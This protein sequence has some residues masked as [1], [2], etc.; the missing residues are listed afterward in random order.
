MEACALRRRLTDLLNPLQGFAQILRPQKLSLDSRLLGANLRPSE[1]IEFASS[2]TL[3]KFGETRAVA[4][5]QLETDFRRLIR[6]TALALQLAEEISAKTDTEPLYRAISN[7]IAEEGDDVVPRYRSLVAEAALSCVPRREERTQFLKSFGYDVPLPP[8]LPLFPWVIVFILDFALFL[9]PSLVMLNLGGHDPNLR[10]APLALF[11]CV[12]AISQTV[13]LTW[14]I[15]P[16][17]VSNF[18][19][20]SLYSWPRESYVV[21]GLASY[22]SGA[23][24]LFIFRLVFP[25]PFPIVLPTLVSSLSFLLM[26]VGIS[27]LIDRRLRSGSL[28]FEQGRLGDGLIM[29]ALMVAGTLT[30]QGTIFYLFPALGWLELGQVPSFVPIRLLFLVLSAGL[31]FVLGYFVPAATAAFMQKAHLLRLPDQLE[32]SRA[33]L[34]PGTTATWARLS[35]Q[36]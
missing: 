21:F 27:F 36:A 12:H 31:G 7:F 10:F 33:E 23:I 22:A 16:K 18:A 5:A 14:A 34:R 15:Y 30:F 9:V 2:K 8:A 4:F 11:A 20:P 24:I 29:G 25:I 17:I 6:R 3:R 13:A 19:R 35:P 26:T 32:G 28:D 1:E